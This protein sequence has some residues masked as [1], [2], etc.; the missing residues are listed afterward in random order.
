MRVPRVFQAGLDAEEDPDDWIVLD[1]E[2]PPLRPGGGPLARDVATTFE[3]G[4][5]SEGI[6]AE[7]AAYWFTEPAGGWPAGKR[8]LRKARELPAPDDADEVWHRGDA[9][10]GRAPL[11]GLARGARL[12]GA[13]VKISLHHGAFVDV[14]AECDGLLPI[15]ELHQ[16]RAL[17]EAAPAVGD[18]LEVEVAAARDVGAGVPWRFPLELAPAGAALAA[19]LAAARAADV[20]AGRPLWTPPLDLR[21]AAL[22]DYPRLA[23][24]A[25]RDWA[26]AKVVVG[27]ER[28]RAGWR[29]PAE[30]TERELAALDAI[31]AGD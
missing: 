2:A 21:G 17:G 29:A 26:P 19:A 24:A 28:S 22:E 7:A 18:R 13:V 11:A 5:T 12:A 10:A 16:W 23:E 15:T 27:R 30:P 1:P 31:A 4:L 14:G 3:E 6:D 25:G 9:A 20:E 8:R